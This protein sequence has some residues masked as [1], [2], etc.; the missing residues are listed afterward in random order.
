MKQLIYSNVSALERIKYINI[1]MKML[2]FNISHAFQV[3]LPYEG[4]YGPAWR[5]N[6][7]DTVVEG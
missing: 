1:G 4:M 7:T 6:E 2:N 3:P 5:E